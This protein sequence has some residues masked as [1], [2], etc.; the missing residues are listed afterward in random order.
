MR[1][2]KSKMQVGIPF[3]S[4]KAF[5]DLVKKLDLTTCA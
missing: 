5:E 2:G 4:L 3:I 1:R